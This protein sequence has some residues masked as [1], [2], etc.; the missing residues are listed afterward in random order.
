MIAYAG[1]LQPGFNHS[2]QYISELGEKGSATARLM[3]YG[4]FLPAGILYVAFGATLR[5]VFEGRVARTAAALVV[6]NGLCRI[7]AGVFPCNPGCG[8]E[9]SL[10][11]VMH[12]LSGATGFLSLIAA[13]IVW[14]VVFR[15]RAAWAQL[16]A[17]SVVTGGIALTFLL[18]TAWSPEPDTPRGLFE[19]VS[20]GVLSVWVFIVAARLSSLLSSSDSPGEIGT[21]VPDAL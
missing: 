16:T 4:C 12:T 8:G 15:R 7:V 11:A 19:R 3:L 2:T 6:L 13:T 21:R 9:R 18:L 20:S 14:G 5:A 17:Y 1:T 10:T